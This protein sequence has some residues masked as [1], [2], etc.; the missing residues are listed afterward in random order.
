MGEFDGTPPRDTRRDAG[1]T[2]RED[3][4]V[5]GPRAASETARDGAAGGASLMRLPTVL[6]ERYATVAELPVQGAESD[7]L[8]VRDAA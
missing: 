2:R 5:P 7:L 8:L 3:A 1:A 6:G 4:R